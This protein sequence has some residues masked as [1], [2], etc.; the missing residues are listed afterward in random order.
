MQEKKTRMKS[1]PFAKKSVDAFYIIAVFI[2]SRDD[3]LDMIFVMGF[4]RDFENDLFEA[5]RD[6][7]LIV[8]ELDDIGILFCENAGNVQKLPR[9]V[10]KRD[11]KTEYAAAGDQS[12]VDQSGD[13]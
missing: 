8:I 12:L 5:V 6:F 10:G 1:G 2:Q 11:G 4:H 3:S 7:C 13:G 9:L